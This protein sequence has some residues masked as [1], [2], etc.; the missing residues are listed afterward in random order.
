MAKKKFKLNPGD[1]VQ[2]KLEDGDFCY[3]RI[4]EEPMVAF[5]DKKDGGNSTFGDVILAPILFKI[6][7]M[8]YAVTSGRWRILGTIPL[9]E[10]LRMPVWFFNEDSIS[11]E[12]FLEMNFEMIP[13]T[14]EECEGLER[15]A[16]WDPE[17]VEDRLRDH[18]LGKPNKWVESLK[19]K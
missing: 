9:E 16:V 18:F 11:K 14:R 8:N 13:A 10:E 19:L 17:H 12:L 5:Y 4:L 6:C 3:G 1:I 2:I 15:S 7:V